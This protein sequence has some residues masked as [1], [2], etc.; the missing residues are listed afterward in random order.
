MKQSI[1]ELGPVNLTAI[2]EF[3]RVQERHAF[4]T[5]QRN[6][7]LE[8]KETLHEAIKEMDGEMSTRFHDTFTNVRSQFKTYFVSCLAEDRQILY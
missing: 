3:E 2:D 5:E 7:L 8:A 4:L 6:D 1:E